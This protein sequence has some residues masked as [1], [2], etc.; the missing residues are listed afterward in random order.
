M[1]NIFAVTGWRQDF[2]RIN[3]T[4]LEVKS[5]KVKFKNG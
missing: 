1:Q 5:Q 4:P 3:L 2:Y